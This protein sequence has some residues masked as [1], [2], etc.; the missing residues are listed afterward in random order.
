MKSDPFDVRVQ[1]KPRGDAEVS[2]IL[3]LDTHLA[4]LLEVDARALQ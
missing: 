4:V 3:E 2:E 1:Y